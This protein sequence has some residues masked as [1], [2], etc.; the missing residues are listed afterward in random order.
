LSSDPSLSVCLGELDLADGLNHFTDFTATAGTIEERT[1][2]KAFDDG[3]PTTVEVFVVP[4][5]ARS[6]RIGESFISADGS[7]IRN[8]VI[9]DRSGVHSRT[10]SYTLAHEI[11]HIFLD[12]PGHPDDYG[13]DRPDLLMDSD[14]ADASIFG[15]R[16]L[17]LED[18]ERALLQSG[19]SAPVPLLQPWPLPRER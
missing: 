15:P 6:T 10:R 16:R 12:M 11:G 19:P 4:A 18:C 13:V 14:A 1:L 17:L 2:V 3:D 5:F 9:I 8:V 7:S